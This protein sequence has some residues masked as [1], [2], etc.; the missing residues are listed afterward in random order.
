MSLKLVLDRGVLCGYNNWLN[1]NCAV[2]GV[3]AL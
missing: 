1:N 2:I 3:S